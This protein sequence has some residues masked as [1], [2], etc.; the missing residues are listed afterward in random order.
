MTHRTPRQAEVDG[1]MCQSQQ[2]NDSDESTRGT[3]ELT[4]PLRVLIVKKEN[5]ENSNPHQC[6]GVRAESLRCP[7]NPVSEEQVMEN[8]AVSR[9]RVS[10]GR[11]GYL[12][13]ACITRLYGL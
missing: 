6:D 8:V 7:G 5:M 9:R 2:H 3:T 11:E 13:E 10:G 4:T 1:V 12:S